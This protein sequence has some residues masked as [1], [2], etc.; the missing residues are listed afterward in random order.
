[1]RKNDFFLV[2]PKVLPP[3]FSG[4]ILAKQLLAD[5]TASS[6]SQA[7]K[8]AGI[9]RSAFYKYRDYVFR[10]SEIHSNYL[11]LNAVL[12]DKAGVFSAMTTALYKIGANILTI[13][14]GI[15]MDGTAAVSLTIENCSGELSAEHLID[16]LKG[17]DGVLSVKAL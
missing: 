4:V 10:D 5:G 1:M 3:V 8:M 16:T 6:S 12:T 14:Q 9:S 17:V 2:S 13:H 15:P 7:A 11:S